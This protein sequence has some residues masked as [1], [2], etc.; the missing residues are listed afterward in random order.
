MSCSVSGA[1]GKCPLV[2]SNQDR[3]GK[4]NQPY[5]THF[6]STM[7][8]R[9][10]FSVGQLIYSSYTSMHRNLRQEWDGWTNQLKVVYLTEILDGGSWNWLGEQGR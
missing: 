2:I 9:T 10:E 5:F 4:T 3:Q 6:V 1:L 8:E 7:Q